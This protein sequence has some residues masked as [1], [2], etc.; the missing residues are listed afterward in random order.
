MIQRDSID[1]TRARPF[2]RRNTKRLK[3]TRKRNTLNSRI[4]KVLQNASEL[5]FFEVQVPIT[6][7]AIAGCVSLSNVP[8][9]V[10]DQTRVGDSLQPTSIK[11]RFIL[12]F[13]PYVPGDASL[14]RFVLFQWRADDNLTVPT[15]NNV[16]LTGAALDNVAYNL[17]HDQRNQIKVLFDRTYTL[18]SEGS[19]ATKIISINYRKHMLPIKFNGGGITGSRKIYLVTTFSGTQPNLT[20]VTRMHFRDI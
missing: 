10:T 17:V 15:V 2:A 19:N 9:G 14:V 1:L 5:K 13:A 18:S 4:H 7:I 11:I 8:Q 20:R 3:R 16:F 6:P 12:D